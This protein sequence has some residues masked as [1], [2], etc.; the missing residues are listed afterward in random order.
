MDGLG[1]IKSHITAVAQENAA[2]LKRDAEG[3]AERILEKAKAEAAK[4]T[5]NAGEETEKEA[6]KTLQRYQSMADTT[7]K[8]AF[9]SSKQSMISACI[10][11]AKDLILGQDDASYFAMIAKL[12][13][14]KLQAKDG[15]LYLSG[16][17]KSR[18]PEGF[19]QKITSEAAAKGG[20][21]KVSDE[22]VDIDGGF[23]LAYGGIDENCS[24][25][26]LFEEHAEELSDIVGKMLFW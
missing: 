18:L 23:V 20:T 6:E 7:R 10:A 26:A 9:L 21:L 5:E 12:L 14:E 22:A 25:S 16:K 19:L 11:K 15:I 3:Q 24:V 17:D 8:Q 4:I 1:K 13:G 2:A